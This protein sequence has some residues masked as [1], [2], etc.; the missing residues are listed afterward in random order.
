LAA[1]LVAATVGCTAYYLSRPATQPF[2]A[3]TITTHLEDR[4]RLS[5]QDLAA[6]GIGLLRRA[7]ALAKKL[8]PLTPEER[9]KE[10]ANLQPEFERFPALKDLLEEVEQNMRN[11]TVD[12]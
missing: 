6:P 12:H 5:R 10:L 1:L 11:Q 2:E 3:E 8:A 7:I 9:E 4:E